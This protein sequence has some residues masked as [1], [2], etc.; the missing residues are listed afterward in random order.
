MEEEAVEIA[1]TAETEV[2]D[3]PSRAPEQEADTIGTIQRS[4]VLHH[5]LATQRR[6][7]VDLLGAMTTTSSLWKQV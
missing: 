1:G 5:L 6:R 7:R 4:P 2:A 3:S